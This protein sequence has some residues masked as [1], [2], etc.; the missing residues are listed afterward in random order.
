MVFHCLNRSGG[1]KDSR[2]NW[3]FAFLTNG[4]GWHNNHHADPRSA[5]HGHR[6]WE[7]DVTYMTLSRLE[8][9]GLIKD[10]VRAHHSALD[11]KTI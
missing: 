6:W 8:K 5:Q 11:C 10:L 7:F 9:L 2:N 4:N 1:Q 3:L